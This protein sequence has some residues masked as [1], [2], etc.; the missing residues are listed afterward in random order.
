MTA[1]L[2]TGASIVGGEVADLL[3]DNGEIV[4]VGTN[5]PAPG[6]T[7]TIDAQGLIALPQCDISARSRGQERVPGCAISSRQ[8]SLAAA[9]WA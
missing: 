3:I 1:Y 4:A 2:I 9:N 8:D 5:L 7:T 6:G